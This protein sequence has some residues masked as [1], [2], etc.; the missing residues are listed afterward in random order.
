MRNDKKQKKVKIFLVSFAFILA[1]GISPVSASEITAQKMVELTNES[2]NEAG[3]GS[4]TANAK[5]AQAAKMKAEDML[6]KQYFEHTSPEGVTPWHWFN[7]AGYEYVYAAE[8]LAIDFVT[9]EGAHSALMKSTGH[10]ENILGASYKDIGVAV[11]SGEFEG[12]DS[13]I[14]VEEFGSRR[15]QKIT[16]NNAPFF[17]TVSEEKSEVKTTEPAKTAPKPKS[18][19]TPVIEKAKPKPAPVA[20]EVPVEKVEAKAE[21]GTVPAAL[22]END[23][24]LTEEDASEQEIKEVNEA[25]G[26]TIPKVYAVRNFKELKKVYMEDIYWKRAEKGELVESLSFDLVRMKIMIESLTGSILNALL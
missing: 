7:L 22:P 20:I 26:K 5:L 2:R 12:N 4:L 3:L 17:E 10:R 23:E 11:V 19:T 8:N 14:I 9:A 16:V 24:M 21:V 6:A 25:P 18:Q 13:I 15:E 1:A